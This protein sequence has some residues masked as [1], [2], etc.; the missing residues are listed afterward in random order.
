MRTTFQILSWLALAATIVPSGMFLAG[1]MA[2][3]QVKLTMFWATV[4][5][6]V[7]TPMWMGRPRE[8][9]PAGTTVE[10]AVT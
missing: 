5:W 10:P 7:F 8:D 3:D 2:L 4:A 1:A 9:Q 6:F